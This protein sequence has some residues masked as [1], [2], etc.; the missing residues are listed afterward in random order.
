MTLA[1]TEARFVRSHHCI[2][3]A[4][5]LPGKEPGAVANVINVRVLGVMFSGGDV[6][7][8]RVSSADGVCYLAR[9][10]WLPPHA[11]SLTLNSSATSNAPDQEH[12]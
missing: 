7:H 11:K 9:P 6:H 1:N 3:I 12:D 5:H 10:H 2:G 8:Y 4:I